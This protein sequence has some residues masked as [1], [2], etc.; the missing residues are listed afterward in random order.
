MRKKQ[1][2]IK[3]NAFKDELEYVLYGLSTTLQYCLFWIVMAKLKSCIV[4]LL[5]EKHVLDILV[6][7]VL[8]IETLLWKW[9]IVFEQQF[10]RQLKIYKKCMYWH[11]NQINKERI[12]IQ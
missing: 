5:E 4:N 7:Q 9:S 3:V 11:E 10:M 2:H 12:K 1:K 8:Y 6:I